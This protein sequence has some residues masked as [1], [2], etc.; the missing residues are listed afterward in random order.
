VPAEKSSGKRIGIVVVNVKENGYN[1]PF[2]FLLLCEENVCWRKG[3]V[4][5]QKKRERKSRR[6]E[7]S[8]RKL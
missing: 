2:T 4:R 8:F 7:N 1:K 6:K 3:E 5:R